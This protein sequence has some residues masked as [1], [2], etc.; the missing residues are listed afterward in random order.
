M[1]LMHPYP[2]L[3]TY[4]HWLLTELVSSWQGPY[5]TAPSGMGAGGLARETLRRKEIPAIWD[6]RRERVG[7]PHLVHFPETLQ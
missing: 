1:T 3:C 6:Y 5:P 7:A 4:A 2:C